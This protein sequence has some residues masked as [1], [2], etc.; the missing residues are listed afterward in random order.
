MLLGLQKDKQDLPEMK[1]RLIER[2]FLIW[3]EGTEQAQ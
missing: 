3:L 2:G 1:T